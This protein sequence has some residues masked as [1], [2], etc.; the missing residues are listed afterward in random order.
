MSPWRRHAVVAGGADPALKSVGCN[1]PEIGVDAL[2]GGGS[3][4]NSDAN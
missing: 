3:L 2:S 4:L 1:D